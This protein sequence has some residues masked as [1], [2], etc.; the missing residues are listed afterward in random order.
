MRASDMPAIFKGTLTAFV[1]AVGLVVVGFL[2]H[3]QSVAILGYAF[4]YSVGLW[5]GVSASK[6]N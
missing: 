3:G 5:A 6:Q 1:A 2:A 4:A